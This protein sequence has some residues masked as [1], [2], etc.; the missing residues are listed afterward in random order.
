MRLH[1]ASSFLVTY[2]A[3]C[4]FVDAFH[5]KQYIPMVNIYKWDGFGL[6]FSVW[7]V[8]GKLLKLMCF[9]SIIKGVR[10]WVGKKECSLVVRFF[11]L[12]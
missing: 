7:G 1:I 12:I 4:E 2:G 6:N 5:A 10:N 8:F 9:W 11:Y 3:S